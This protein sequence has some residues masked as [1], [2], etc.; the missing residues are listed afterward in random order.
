MIR[1]FL[2]IGTICFGL[3]FSQPGVAQDRPQAYFAEWLWP[4]DGPAIR[5]A[6]LI[7]HQ[8]K[9]VASGARTSTNV[10]VDSESHH[11]GSSVIMPGL[12]AVDTNLADRGVPEERNVTPENLALDAF[13]FFRENESLLEAGI[14]TVQ[15]T[16][17]KSRLMP[18]QGTVVKLAGSNIEERILR[19]SQSI[20]LDLT[21]SSLNAGTIYEPPVG[22][23]SVDRPLEPSRPQ[24]GTSLLEVSVGLRALL[25]SAKQEGT[26]EDLRLQALAQSLQS[27]QPFWIAAETEP[28]IA[29][30]AKLSAEFELPWVLVGPRDIQSV[31]EE[32]DW[33]SERLQ[34]VI[35]NPDVKPGELANSPVPERDAPRDSTPGERARQLKKS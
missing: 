19:E 32:I 2:V 16:A 20:K 26:S 5:D 33:S 4:G 31:L 11:L 18:G 17:G 25:K 23:V 22:A 34:G 7:V 1:W 24:L 9:I 13:D 6:V 10:P 12:I 35:L 30:A 28:E 15:I 8:G 14:T 29:L 27:R 3:L 21:R